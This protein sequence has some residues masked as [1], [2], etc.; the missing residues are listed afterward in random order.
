[1]VTAKYNTYVGMRYVPIF[2]GEWDRTKTY[3]PLVIVSNQGNSYTSRTFVP[4]GIDITNETYW[5]LTGNYNAQ[6]EYYRQETA[7][8]AEELKT[9]AKIYDTV[10]DMVE[11]MTLT[12]GESC[13]TL[14]YYNI[15]DNGATIY[16]LVSTPSAYTI[17]LDNG[18]YAMPIIS[19]SVTP[20]MF[21]AYGD[22]IHDDTSALRLALEHDAVNVILTKT[23]YT[24]EKITVTKNKIITGGGTIKCPSFDAKQ[25]ILYFTCEDV[26]IENIHFNSIRDNDNVTPPEGHTRDA[27]CLVSNVW[28]ICGSGV[29]H[30][31]VD[32]VTFDNSEYDCNFYDCD[33]V[34][35]NNFISNNA[36]MCTYFSGNKYVTMTNGYIKLYPLLG[37]GDHAIYACYGNDKVVIDNVDIISSDAKSSHYP[38]HVFATAE[39]ITQYGLTKDVIITNCYIEYAEQ[40][41]ATM[42]E[43]QFLVSNS[44]LIAVTT[45]SSDKL[46]YCGSSSSGAYFCIKDSI[47]RAEENY[48]TFTNTIQNCTLYLINCQ[49]Q[50]ETIRFEDVYDTKIIFDGCRLKNIVGTATFDSDLEIYRSQIVS[51]SDFAIY[52]NTVGRSVKI[53]DCYLVS[54]GDGLI[55]LRKTGDE[56]L[57]LRCTGKKTG[58][59][60]KLEYNGDFT[61]VINA[62]YCYFPTVMI[63]SN[64][65]NNISST[66]LS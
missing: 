34:V 21:G 28:F 66:F 60:N 61:P 43:K 58:T 50:W 22:G 33:N 47:I 27:E 7:R 10:S 18:L 23:Y 8:V 40:C 20:E 26:T 56:M 2:D 55:S 31:T 64:A 32:N 16:E 39:Q 54:S 38:I 15:N 14:G 9:R 42:V 29:K 52:L 11:D 53:E 30:F 3:E 36:S 63:R 17:E 13:F 44:K 51:T 59:S 12:L 19:D 49:M 65:V 1:M 6:V 45:Q 37:T 57:L 41:F 62:A 4:T 24:A 35:I 5:A 25:E 46:F 48:I